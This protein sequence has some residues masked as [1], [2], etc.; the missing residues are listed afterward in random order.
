M[1][2]TLLRLSLDVDECL[3]PQVHGC[4]HTCINTLGSYH[5]T[6]NPGYTLNTN[7]RT[8]TGKLY[9]EVL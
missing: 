3:D 2:V 5:C 6:C 8:C 4:Q 7:E 1:K 9:T